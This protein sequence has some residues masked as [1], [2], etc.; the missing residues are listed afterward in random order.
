MRDC[1]SGANPVII[2]GGGILLCVAGVAEV[3]GHNL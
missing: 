1:F 3:L 2:L